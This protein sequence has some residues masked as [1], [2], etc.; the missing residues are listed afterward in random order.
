MIAI[1]ISQVE[2]VIASFKKEIDDYQAVLYAS[3]SDFCGTLADPTEIRYVLHLISVYD[4]VI[5]AHPVQLAIYQKEFELI[6]DKRTIASRAKKT[7]RNNLI[8]A[9]GYSGLR[10]TFYPEYF[11]KIGIKACVYCNS[12]LTVSV[13]KELVAGTKKKT[14]QAKFQADH[15]FPKNENPCLSI[16]LYNLYPVCANCNVVKGVKKVDFNLYQNGRKFTSA[17]KFKLKDGCKAD[18]I[19]SRDLKDIVIE[20]TESAKRRGYQQFNTLFNIKGIYDT[21]LDIASELILKAEAYTDAY[22]QS[23]ESSL[24]EIFSDRETTNRLLLGNYVEEKDNHRRPLAKFSRD[25]AI[26][27]GLLSKLAP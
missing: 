6:I 9:I 26:S 27:V 11:Q 14:F 2:S 8:A 3:L 12:I 25:I 13:E 19:L 17:F 20:F 21:Q 15:Y 18:Y 22:K 10:S 23:L 7:F 5:R 16:S 1:S 4:R 24:S